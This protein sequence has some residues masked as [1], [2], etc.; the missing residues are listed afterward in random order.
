[1]ENTQTLDL[2]TGILALAILI[3][4]YLMMHTTVFTTKKKK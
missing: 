1:M 2:I 4:A 3:G